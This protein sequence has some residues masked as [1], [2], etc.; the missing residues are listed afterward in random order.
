VFA[1]LKRVLAEEIDEI[2]DEDDQPGFGASLGGNIS[3]DY[4]YYNASWKEDGAGVKCE[5]WQILSPVHATGAGVSELNRAI[6]RHFRADHIDQAINASGWMRKVPKPMG[7]EGI[8]YGAKVMC[9]KNHRHRDVYPDEFSDD[10]PFSGPS[11]FVANGEIGMVVGQFKRRGQKFRV[12][13]L[14]VEFSTQPGAKYGFG[15]G[16]VPKE[17]DPILELAYAI[18]VHKSQGS[19]FG[20]TFLVIPNPS[21]LLSRELLYTALTRQ[22]KRVVVLHQGPLH[23]LLAYASVGNAETAR[24][25]TNLFA[26]PDPVDVGNG[27]YLEDR[28]IHRTKNGTLVRSKSEIVIADA[29]ADSNVGFEYEQPFEGHDGTIRLPDF[30]IEDAATG[31]RYLWEHLGMLSNPDY[32]KAW[33]RKKAWYEA[34]G[35]TE[36]GGAVATLIVTEDDER[37]GLDS[38]EIHG[39]VRAL[40]A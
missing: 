22:T 5:A 23:N 28:L 1:L 20:T 14:E 13:K 39:R 40:F 30:T 8:V 7:P 17:G 32:R 35:V 19:E 37:G 2:G 6:H 21:Q 26:D 3:G 25:S 34:S 9:I 11:K 4:V 24:R 33:E 10:S 16:Y 12:T 27:R 38:G 29:L 18:T 31:D 36:A 15:R